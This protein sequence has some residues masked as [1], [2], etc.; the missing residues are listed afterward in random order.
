MWFFEP[1]ARNELLIYKE[2]VDGSALE[3]IRSIQL[4]PDNQTINNCRRSG[5]P[6][7]LRREYSH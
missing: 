6:V 3:E 4:R 7:R 5:N 2:N 1:I